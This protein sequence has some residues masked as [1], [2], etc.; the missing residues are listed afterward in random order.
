LG[1]F[2]KS[3]EIAWNSTWILVLG[4]QTLISAVYLGPI[5]TKE[6]QYNEKLIVPLIFLAIQILVA[7]KTHLLEGEKHPLLKRRTIAALIGSTGLGIIL[8]GMNPQQ[9]IEGWAVAGYITKWCVL[10][11]LYITMVSFLTFEKGSGAPLVVSRL[12]Q[13]IWAL[14]LVM[15]FW[16]PQIAEPLLACLE[17]GCKAQAALF[18][19]DV[20]STMF[21]K[22]K[23]EFFQTIVMAL[24]VPLIFLASLLIVVGF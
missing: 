9:A 16:P 4:L 8:Y 7:V 1:T 23:N 15:I 6:W 5:F 13:A 22:V 14:G 10:V 2:W 18:L 17:Q 11:F 21:A 3:R 19:L 24:V 12:S 20:T